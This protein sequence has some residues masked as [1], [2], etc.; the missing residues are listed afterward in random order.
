VSVPANIEEAMQALLQ[1]LSL[2]DQVAITRMTEDEVGGLHHT[3]GQWMR[4]NWGLW[5]GSPLQE[6][7]KSL[8]FIHADDMSSSIIREFWARMNKL[9]SKIAQDIEGYKEFWKKNK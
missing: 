8:G 6:H 1:K 7:M 3:L 5:S 4:N 2:E 9:P